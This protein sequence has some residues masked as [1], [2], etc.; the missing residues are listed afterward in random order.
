MNN[1]DN[2]MSSYFTEYFGKLSPS[3]NQNKLLA[4]M[5]TKYSLSSK[6]MYHLYSS[7]SYTDF[8]LIEYGIEQIICIEPD[9]DL[10]RS[11]I[12]LRKDLRTLNK[13]LVTIY[14][15]NPLSNEFNYSNANI[16][17]ISF[18]SDF[19]NILNKINNECKSNTL[20]IIESYSNPNIQLTELYKFN[21]TEY[22]KIYFYKL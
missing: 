16:I 6:I 9:L 13:E 20:L 19:T 3:I 10:T 11:A 12:L 22:I 5:I 7:E 21:L 1:I 14:N 8:T 15:N 4:K 18:Q 17:F 2:Y